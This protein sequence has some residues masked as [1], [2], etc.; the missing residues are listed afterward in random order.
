MY[1]EYKNQIVH[2]YLTNH[3]EVELYTLQL[4]N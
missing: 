3:G 2:N 1:M 4:R